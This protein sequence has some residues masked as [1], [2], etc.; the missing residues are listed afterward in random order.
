MGAGSTSAGSTPAGLDDVDSSAVVV[1]PTLQAPLYDPAIRGFAF[2]AAGEYPIQ[3]HPVIERAA[4]LLGMRRGASPSNPNTGLRWE[5]I[6][7]APDEDVQNIATD[8][9]RIALKPL[10]DAGDILI[11]A[12]EVERDLGGSR[13]SMVVTVS[14][15][16]EP[17]TPNFP[18]SEPTNP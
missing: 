5:K 8:E 7:A 13:T 10:L 9:V 14:N 4:L 12:V 2:E 1:L 16:R 17:G 6:A 18:S 3:V 15:L 11:V